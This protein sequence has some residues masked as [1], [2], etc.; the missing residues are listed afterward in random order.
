MSE[1][2]KAKFIVFK[3]F[4]LYIFFFEHR[5]EIYYSGYQKLNKTTL[6]RDYKSNYYQEDSISLNNLLHS[7]QTYAPRKRTFLRTLDKTFG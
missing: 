1:M 6:Y 2:I 3:D 5:K 4:F 7:L